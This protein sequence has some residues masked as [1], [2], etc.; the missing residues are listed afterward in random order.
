MDST[1][2]SQHLPSRSPWLLIGVTIVA[3]LGAHLFGLLQRQPS[4]LDE[5]RVLAARPSFPRSIGEWRTLADRWDSYLTDHFPPRT[6]IIGLV[7]YARYRLG[8]SGSKK[9]VVGEN[10]WLFYDD[11]S[12][13]AMA[14]GKRQL[15]S[16]QISDWI[17]GFKERQAYLKARRS[18]FYML[19]GPVQEDIFPENR[20]T[21]MPKHTFK[22]E[23]D[24]ILQAAQ[25]SGIDAIVDPRKGLVAAKA[26]TDVYDQFDTHWTGLGAYIAYSELMSRI[27]Q[28][29]PDMGPLPLSYFVPTRQ[30]PNQTARALSLMLGI[31]DFVPHDRVSYATI[32][33]HDPA[34]TI[35]LSP[36]HDWTA[37]Q[38]LLTGRGEGKTLLLLRDSFATEL[39][40]FLKPH[41]SRIITAHLQDGAFR[42]DLIRRFKPDVVIVEVIETGARHVMGPLEDTV[43]TLSPLVSIS[44]T[45]PSALDMKST[46]AVR[47]CNVEYI[48]GQLSGHSVSVKRGSTMTVTGWA[49][50]AAH[51]HTADAIYLRF[52]DQTS[53]SYFA[54]TEPSGSRPDVTAAF[55][56]DRSLDRSGFRANV[57]MALPK[58]DY[59]M[60]VVMQVGAQT[61]SCPNAPRLVVT[62]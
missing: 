18:S 58:G 23:V 32:P 6:Q 56:L 38:I 25:Q 5:N 34:Q 8:Y 24:Q 44:P 55:K 14:A 42:E 21:W 7:N 47:S 53:P 10:G 33:I 17:G 13:L 61:V 9:V 29:Y 37:P 36:R 27:H 16:E 3:I 15:T 48:N 52:R 2:R 39:L 12:H 19:L 54:P 49:L 11:G 51:Q 30:G 57:D 1:T 31:A 22:T 26:Q 59:E 43:P 50:D 4:G 46:A 60:S 28:D 45:P 20:P 35:F 40:P 41:F 62:Q